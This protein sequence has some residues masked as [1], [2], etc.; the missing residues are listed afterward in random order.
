MPV[1]QSLQLPYCMRL[2]LAS[3]VYIVI[4]PCVK[5]YIKPGTPQMY[6]SPTVDMGT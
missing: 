1:A 2:H 6:T 4:L 5:V 3:L